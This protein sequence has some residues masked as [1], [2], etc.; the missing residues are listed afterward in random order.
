[1]TGRLGVFETGPGKPV[2]AGGREPSRATLM[3][4]KRSSPLLMSLIL[5][6]LLLYSWQVVIGDFLFFSF[7]F[8]S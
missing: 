4:L 1:M 5:D 7:Q 3:L 2:V 8:V 6:A